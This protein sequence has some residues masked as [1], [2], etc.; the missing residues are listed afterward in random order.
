MVQKVTVEIFF[1]FG[2]EQTIELNSDTNI[3]VG[4]NGKGKT[5]F[6][7]TIRLLQQ[8]IKGNF[9]SFIPTVFNHSAA[10]PL[11]YSLRH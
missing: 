7:R 10:V 6:I 11:Y 9:Y 5:N 1:S 2:T 8:G 4:I 3:L